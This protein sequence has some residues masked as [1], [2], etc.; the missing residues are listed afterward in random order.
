APEFRRRASAVNGLAYRC[1]CPCK[2]NAQRVG[3][4]SKTL[5]NHLLTGVKD[6]GF[7]LGPTT[8]DTYDRVLRV[9]ASSRR[10]ICFS[11]VR[12]HSWGLDPT[13]NSSFNI[14]DYS[15]GR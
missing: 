10:E 9:Q 11:T 13:R 7:S 14:L 2:S 3:W 12:A 1:G 15:R 8:I 6:D 4:T 5:T